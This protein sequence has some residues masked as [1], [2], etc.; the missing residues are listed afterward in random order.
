LRVDGEIL[1]SVEPDNDVVD[2]TVEDPVVVGKYV[3]G[4]SVIVGSNVVVV[5]EGDNKSVGVAVGLEV[6]ET[7]VGLVVVDTKV[8]ASVG[9]CV[10]SFVPIRRIGRHIKY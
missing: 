10:G 7:E 3:V 5:G 9:C 6:G 2:D 4:S 8:G 1:L